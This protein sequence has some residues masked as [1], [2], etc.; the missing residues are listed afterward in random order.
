M[1]FHIQPIPSAMVPQM[2]HYALPYI[3]RA[4]DHASGEVSP[5][6]LQRGCESRDM[7]LWLVASGNRV[8]GAV[9]TEIVVYPRRK[10]CRVITLAGSGF[11]DWIELCDNV[12]AQ[13]AK[14]QGCDA[15]EAHVRKGFVPKLADL[16]WRHKHS[17]VVK[18]LQ[19]E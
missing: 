12:L 18:E 1:T 7:Q 13:F 15:L 4:L 19:H 6:D 9:T 8:V 11:A 16:A 10:H 17:T 14:A 5:E 3:K 2:W